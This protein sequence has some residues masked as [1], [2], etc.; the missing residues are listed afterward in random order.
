MICLSFS[1]DITKSVND[2]TQKMISHMLQHNQSYKSLEGMAQIVNSTPNSSIRVPS[3]RYKLKNTMSSQLLIEYHVR[4]IKCKKYSVT[5]KP[6]VRSI[7]NFCNWS[8]STSD[9]DYFVYIPL[10]PQLQKIINDNFEEIFSYPASEEEN[11]ITDIHNSI[12]FKKVA[13]KYNKSKILSMVVCTDGAAVFRS[14]R[15]SLWA[16]QLY[17]NFLKPIK[18]YTPDNILVVA[19]YCGLEKP[20]MNEFFGP[21]ISE[22]EGIVNYGGFNLRKNGHIYNFVT[23]ITHCCC[24]LPAKVDVQGMT[25][26]SGYSACGYCLHP[27]ISIK[28]NEKTKPYVRYVNR[29]EVEV[30]RTHES[31]LAAYKKLKKSPL[32]IDGVKSVSCLSALKDFDLVSGFAID[33]MHC[34]LLGIMR[35]LLDLWLN[36]N[37]KKEQFYI[38]PKFQIVLNKRIKSIKPTSDISRK[39]RPMTDRA[40]FKANE[41]RS[42]LLYY[43][44]FALHGVL[45]KRYIQHFHLLSTA[46]YMLLEERI[47]ME[48]VAI[49]EG[50]LIKF[51]D[52]F[53][54]LYGKSNVTINLHLLRHCASAVR[55]LGPLWAQSAF[56]LEANNGILTKTTAKK[57]V[58]HSIAWKYAA[59]FALRNADRSEI[60]HGIFVGGEQ[61]IFLNQN[62]LDALFNFELV[63]NNLTTFRHITINGKKYTSKKS[64]PTASIDFFVEICD[65]TIGIIEFFFLHNFVA[66]ALIEVYNVVECFDHFKKVRTAGSLKAVQAAD[67][68]KKLIYM[69]VNNE[70][71]I[72]Q[73]PNRFEKT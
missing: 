49:S 7:C 31:I 50:R 52:D 41:L 65:G 39:P 64:K 45:Q 9:S 13:A 63:Q 66:Y 42:F 54:T 68:N 59:K 11:V 26:H 3:T 16:I 62:E 56:G 12:Q 57:H 33:Y 21:L 15:K 60:N 47:E 25:G 70:E 40:D 72:T 22:V 58:L 1:A 18:R 51:A 6:D 61:D 5:T 2:H 37:N 29:G 53:E 73:I 69:N 17:L 67:I 19:L 71:V 23:L 32:A 27:G 14:S 38:P 10:L 55:N 8:I 43:L 44:R 20:A 4:C 35:K 30:F 36:S 48:N 24:D 28:K 46:I 34:V